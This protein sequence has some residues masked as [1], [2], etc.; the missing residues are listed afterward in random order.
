M[1]TKLVATNES[2][3]LQ[4]PQ[5][6]LLLE[7]HFRTTKL[8]IDYVNAFSSQMILAQKRMFNRIFPIRLYDVYFFNTQ[9]NDYQYIMQRSDKVALRDI[10]KRVIYF[11]S[12][13]DELKRAQATSSI[14]DLLNQIL[15]IT[16][17]VR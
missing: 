6:M 7:S 17:A 9:P 12:V 3:V 4:S 2:T 10:N 11:N 16:R 13:L 1:N 15:E 5:K 14:L 8:S